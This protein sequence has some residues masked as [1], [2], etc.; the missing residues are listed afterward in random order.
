VLLRVLRSPRAGGGKLVLGVGLATVLAMPLIVALAALRTPRWYPILDLAQIEL[1]L[2]DI[3]SRHTPLVGVAGRIFD[4]SGRQ[5]SH[6]GP[7]GLYAIWP[8]YRLLGRT[9]WGMLVGAVTV[10]VVAIA[11]LLWLAVRRGAQ[12]LVLGMGTAAALLVLG[13]GGDAVTSPWNPYLVA[14]WWV[15]FLIAVWSVLCRDFPVLPVAVVAGSFC[16]QNHAEYTALVVVLLA[17]AGSWSVREVVRE[18]KRE[19]HGARTAR[20][21]AVASIVG[22]VVWLPPLVEELRHDPGNFSILLDHFGSPPEKTIGLLR[23]T[24]L[25]LAHMNPWRLVT[26]AVAGEFSGNFIERGTPVPGALLLAVWAASVVVASRR[27]MRDL[28]L[29]DLV[30]GVVVVVGVLSLARVF[31]PV[32]FWIGLWGFGTSALM[33]LATAWAVLPAVAGRLP[34]WRFGHARWGPA[35]AAAILAAATGAAA[36]QAAGTEGHAPALSRVLSALVPRTT[37]ALEAGALP[38]GGRRGRY[39]VTSDDPVNI[40]FHAFGIVNEL[41]REGFRVGMEPS[42]RTSITPHRVV[43]RDR[44]TAVVVLVA[45][46][47]IDEWRHRPEAVEVAVVDD[48]TPAERAEYRRLH[49]G[50]V[51]DFRRAGLDDLVD[52]LDEN[53]VIT[54]LDKRTPPD[55]RERI[56]RMVVIGLPNAIFVTPVDA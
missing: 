24:R 13:Y 55:V 54:S 6:P 42:Y 20:W 3:G 33:L 26:S 32:W 39:L 7:L 37:D 38:G 27:R 10:H 2:R 53:L 47:A 1:R 56:A 40:G 43:R 29:L 8:A 21:L 22:I 12:P 25:L 14:F 52:T 49:D 35:A 46:A 9:A 19:V 41:D 51:E 17:L 30:L 18:R 44:A 36:L 34:D 11:T 5:G 31:G 28:L 48:R 4:D 45:G 50:V 23:G 15:V 16:V